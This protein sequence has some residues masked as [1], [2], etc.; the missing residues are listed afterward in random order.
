MR[1]HT[2]E[3]PYYCVPCN[4]NFKSKRELCR[5]TTTASCRSAGLKF[6][7]ADDLS[8]DVADSKDDL[9][10]SLEVN[11]DPD[12]SDKDE[13]W[14]DEDAN[15]ED[16]DDDATEDEQEVVCGKDEKEVKM[17]FSCEF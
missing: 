12:D 7:P 11:S 9:N 13:D 6:E 8:Q 5:H 2:G 15:G 14:H 3:K 1:T 16:E 10:G 17:P 4:K